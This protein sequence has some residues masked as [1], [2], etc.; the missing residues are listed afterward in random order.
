MPLLDPNSLPDK[1][2]TLLVWDAASSPPAGPWISVLWNSF[3]DEQS[4]VVSLPCYVEAHANLLKERYL[5]WIYELG[6]AVIDGKRVIDH[7]ELRPGFSYWWMTLLSEKGIYGK[8]PQ[9]ADALK[10]LAFEEIARSKAAKIIV[11]S[12]NQLLVKTIRSWCRNAGLPFL[13]QALPGRKGA[14][15]RFQKIY[16]GMPYPL[17][18][19]IFLLRYCKERWPLW[20]RYVAASM[21]GEITFVDYLINL[22][23]KALSSC[24]FAS[25]YWSELLDYIRQTGLPVNWLHHYI[26]HEAVAS[27]SQAADLIRNF[28]YQEDMHHA[29]FIVDNSFSISLLLSVMRDYLRLLRMCHRLSKIKDC[30]CPEGSNIDFWHFFK[31]DW[32]NSMSGPTA[33]WN[34]L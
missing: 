22:D 6:E 34:C 10:M 31:T 24:K 19:I 4:A 16:Q 14:V 28:N 32:F 21:K 11:A 26:R 17:K 3:A 23:K 13:L 15:L 5:T 12:D 2:N 29:H 7:L 20:R 27:S 9:I 25:H 8:S 30:F 18:A 1:R 33:I